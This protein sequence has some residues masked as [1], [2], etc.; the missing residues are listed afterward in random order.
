MYILFKFHRAPEAALVLRKA[1]AWGLDVELE[2]MVSEQ[3]GLALSRLS[4]CARIRGLTYH[5]IV[6]L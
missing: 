5:M 1:A 4:Q 3:A 6:M 2:A